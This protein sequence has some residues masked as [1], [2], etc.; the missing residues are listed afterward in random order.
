MG[1]QAVNSVYAREFNQR[2]RRRGHLFGERF[3]D[4][5]IR[6]EAH[7]HACLAYVLEN[8]VR[9]GVVRRIEEWP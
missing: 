4:T 3:T 8:P 6:S 7:L 9:A 1:E 2:H 5:P